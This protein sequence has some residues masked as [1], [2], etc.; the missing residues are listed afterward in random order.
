MHVPTCRPGMHGTPLTVGMLPGAEH[1]PVNGS[2]Q[3]LGGQAAAGAA[4]TSGATANA[5]AQATVMKN[6]ESGIRTAIVQSPINMTYWAATC[7]CTSRSLGP[8]ASIA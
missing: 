3:K 2:V 8:F 6:L 4:A 1:C 5:A 7:C